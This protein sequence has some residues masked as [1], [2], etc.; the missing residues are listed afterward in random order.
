MLVNGT[1]IV[2]EDV[3]G[4]PH[5]QVGNPLINFG[6]VDHD[7]ASGNQDEEYIQLVN[8]HDTA[9][10][11]TG[12]RLTGGVEHIF[13]FWHGDSFGRFSVRIA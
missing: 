1:F 13:H 12:W 6:E 8:P 5:E 3:A 7:P 4:I 11:L 10:D 9:V 2:N